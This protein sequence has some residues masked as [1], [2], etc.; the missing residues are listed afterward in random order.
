MNKL[1]LLLLINISLFG[2][3]REEGLAIFLN[4]FSFAHAQQIESFKKYIEMTGEKKETAL[5]DLKKAYKLK[6][7]K[8]VIFDL[9]FYKPKQ[10]IK[11][12]MKEKTFNGPDLNKILRKEVKIVKET[13]NPYIAYQGLKLIESYF[14]M[15]KPNKLVR[16]SMP[17][18]IKPLLK[19]NY[20]IGHL[21]NARL[22][23]PDFGSYEL[24]KAVKLLENANIVCKNQVK[25]RNIPSYLSQ[26]IDLLEVKASGLLKL[27]E[28]KARNFK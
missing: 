8:E 17:V 19:R 12:G 21:Y 28:K 27:E 23:M 4:K 11:I 3:A 13:G 24:K 22:H 10:T 18:L 15:S 20:C 6:E 9:Y 16:R 25:N 2:S 26:N 14:L 5:L 1:I 7:W